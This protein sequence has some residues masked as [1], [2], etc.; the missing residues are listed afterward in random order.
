[1]DRGSCQ[2]GSSPWVTLYTIKLFIYSRRSTN[3]YD[4][5]KERGIKFLVLV[6]NLSKIRK[7]IMQLQ[8]C[9]VFLS[10][11]IFLLLSRL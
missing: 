9:F 5:R 11:L 1:M 4:V 7:E 10:L 2:N 3:I 8:K 6:F